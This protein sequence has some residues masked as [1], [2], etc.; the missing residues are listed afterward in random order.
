M[1]VFARFTRLLKKTQ[2]QIFQQNQNLS[3]CQTM[4]KLNL[5]KVGFNLYYFNYVLWDPHSDRNI[6]QTMPK[7]LSGPHFFLAVRQLRYLACSAK[8]TDSSCGSPGGR[9]LC[10]NMTCEPALYGHDK[11]SSDTRV[12]QTDRGSGDKRAA[13]RLIHLF[14]GGEVWSKSSSRFSLDFPFCHFSVGSVQPWELTS[15][16]LVKHVI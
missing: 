12:H 5:F 6:G 14:G 16:N 13:L 1:V 9:D 15:T 2:Y 4:F 10:D 7:V 11:D 3:N 8:G